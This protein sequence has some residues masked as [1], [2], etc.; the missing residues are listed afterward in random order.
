MLAAE[1]ETTN[2]EYETKY[3]ES[4]AYWKRM[5][6]DNKPNLSLQRLLSSKL[7]I[8]EE[9]WKSYIDIEKN[10]LMK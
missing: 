3:Y 4:E 6:T 7:K 2:E 8:D 9:R 10:K 1:T 5:Q